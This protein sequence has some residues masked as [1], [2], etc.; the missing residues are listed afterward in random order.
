[1]CSLSLASSLCWRSQK[2]PLGICW[3]KKL[4]GFLQHCLMP[5]ALGQGPASPP[6]CLVQRQ[7]LGSVTGAGISGVLL[8]L[9]PRLGVEQAGSALNHGGSDV[10]GVQVERESSWGSEIF[11]V[12][13]HSLHLQAGGGVL[14][15]VAQ[16]MR[17]VWALRRAVQGLNP[18]LAT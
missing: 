11:P 12:S 18:D 17:R 13:S 10:G 1:M 3:Q 5:E 15:E 6:L 14:R 9:S 2:V 16:C 7:A 4:P 8:A